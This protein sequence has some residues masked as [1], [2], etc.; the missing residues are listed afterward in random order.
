MGTDVPL[1]EDLNRRM[2][3]GSSCERKPGRRGRGISLRI[4]IDSVPRPIIAS[5]FQE[6]APGAFPRWSV[7][8][9]YLQ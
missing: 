9:L 4:G 2:G 5:P 6:L 8:G 7:A 1:G 3:G